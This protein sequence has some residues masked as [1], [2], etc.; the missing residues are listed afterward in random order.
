MVHCAA[1]KITGDVR[2]LGYPKVQETFARV[3]GYVEQNDIHSAHVRKAPLNCRGISLLLRQERCELP[4]PVRCSQD[5]DS[6]AWEG[7]CIAMPALH[8]C[9]CC[10][11]RCWSLWCIAHGC[12]LAGLSRQTLS[13]HSCKRCALNSA[14]SP[15]I[16][17]NTVLSHPT[18]VEAQNQ[19]QV[20]CSMSQGSPAPF[21]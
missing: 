1:G 14:Q 6:K 9:G 11:S 18:M 4:Y 20:P 8:G 16:S 13:T 7:R 2:V 10:R 3:I 15:S 19:L 17:L 12:A 21:Q 5:P